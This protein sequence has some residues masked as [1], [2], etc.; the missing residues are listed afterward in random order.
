M[1][2][3]FL[4]AP[5]LAQVVADTILMIVGVFWCSSGVQDSVQPKIARSDPLSAPLSDP[6]S[7]PQVCCACTVALVLQSLI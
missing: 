7:A 1:L 6:L 3:C 4:D 5:F 2:S